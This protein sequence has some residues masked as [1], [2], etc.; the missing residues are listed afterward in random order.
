MDARWPHV[1]R[2]A[3]HRDAPHRTTPIL[4]HVYSPHP[5][6]PRRTAPHEGI[7]ACSNFDRSFGARSPHADRYSSIFKHIQA[8]SSILKL[9]LVGLGLFAT[10]WRHPSKRVVRSCAANVRPTCGQMYVYSF[11]RTAPHRATQCAVRSRCGQRAANVR[12]CILTL[13]DL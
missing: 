5:H 3:T 1:G 8:Y 4:V 12:P 9:P 11:G 2:T 7:A 6:A 13:T 10:R